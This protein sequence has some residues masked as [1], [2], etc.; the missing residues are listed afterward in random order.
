M[1]LITVA[2]KVTTEG[3]RLSQPTGCPDALYQLMMRCWSHDS[4]DRPSMQ[5]VEE[6]LIA[7]ATNLTKQPAKK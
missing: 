2:M 3:L 5:A 4:Q 6:E 1:T 7:I